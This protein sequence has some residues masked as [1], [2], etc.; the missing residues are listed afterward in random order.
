[1]FFELNEYDAYLCEGNAGTKSGSFFCAHETKRTDAA[2]ATRLNK[3]VN[4][5]I[6]VCFY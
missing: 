2:I 5:F 3:A 1:M 4:F 6:I